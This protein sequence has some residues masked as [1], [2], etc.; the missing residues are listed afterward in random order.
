VKS[1]IL[2]IPKTEDVSELRKKT[3]E[4]KNGILDIL[5]LNNPT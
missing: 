1:S 4:F 2:Q 5:D 3:Q